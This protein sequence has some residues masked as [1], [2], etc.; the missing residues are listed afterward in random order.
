[1]KNRYR[2]KSISDGHGKTEGKVMLSVQ[3][4]IL[5]GGSGEVVLR[6][7]IRCSTRV[8]QVYVRNRVG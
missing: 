4:V 7:G 3:F 8:F 5:L 6:G 1:M 2:P